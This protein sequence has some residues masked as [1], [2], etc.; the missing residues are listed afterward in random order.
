M[1]IFTMLTLNTSNTELLHITRISFIPNNLGYEKLAEVMKKGVD[2]LVGK[3][4]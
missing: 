3:A 1:F 4:Q 2:Q